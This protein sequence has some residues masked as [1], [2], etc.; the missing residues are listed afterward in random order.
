MDH[1]HIITE[2]WTAHKSQPWQYHSAMRERD[3]E[4]QDHSTT[5]AEDK[6]IWYTLPIK[7]DNADGQITK[8]NNR[9]F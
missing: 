2:E 1:N 7:V 3:R 5:T 8:Q 6:K 4:A 9:L